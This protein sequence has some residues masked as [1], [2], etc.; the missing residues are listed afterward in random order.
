M[1]NQP[2]NPNP[3]G[4]TI[5]EPSALSSGDSGPVGLGPSENDLAVAGKEWASLRDLPPGWKLT[6]Q[7]PVP[8]KKP[9]GE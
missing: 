4:H 9:T 7:Y 1:T 5:T 8:P 6:T 3:S 2:K